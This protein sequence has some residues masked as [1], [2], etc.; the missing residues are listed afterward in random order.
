[1]INYIF[2]PSESCQ[3]WSSLFADVDDDEMQKKW[4]ISACVT[5][6]WVL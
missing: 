3:S 2:I 6:V 5:Q 4:Q 1:M